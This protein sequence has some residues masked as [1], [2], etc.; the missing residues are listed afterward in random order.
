ME[1]FIKHL[2]LINMLLTFESFGENPEHMT[3]LDSLLQNNHPLGETKDSPFDYKRNS[4]LQSNF[5]LHADYSQQDLRVVLRK[6]KKRR[7]VRTIRTTRI[8]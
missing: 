4:V 8:R 5:S 3:V 6:M 2:V 1:R 7:F